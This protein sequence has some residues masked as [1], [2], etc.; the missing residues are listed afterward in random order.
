VLSQSSITTADEFGNSVAIY[1]DT[2]L[3]GVPF[4]DSTS[5]G[6]DGAKTD[7][8]TGFE[9]GAA[10]VYTRSGSTWSE[11][12]YIKASN[13]GGSDEFATAVAL[14]KDSAAIGAPIE[15]GSAT[16]VNGGDDNNRA[17]SGAGYV[18]K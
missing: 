4:D 3:V 8:G 17:D 11:V 12:S 1:N 2:I 10:Y 9:A 14:D 18:Y 5:T 6:V 13:T 7:N 15:A 16:S